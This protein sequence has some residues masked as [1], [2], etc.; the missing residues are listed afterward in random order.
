MSSSEIMEKLLDVQE[1]AE[2]SFGITNILQPG[3][4]KELI[5]AEILG[6][7]LVPQKDLPDA[8]DNE[9][10]FYEYLASIN[11]INTKTNRGCS[12]QMDRVTSNNLTRVTRNKA[13]YFGI[14]RTH[15]E[16]D[17]IWSVD[18]PNVLNEVQ[19]Q[20]ANCKNDIAHVNF[21]L[22]WLKSNGKLVYSNQKEIKYEK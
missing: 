2:K 5:M 21:L 7:K 22:K 20:L 3:I 13:F 16:I 12:F 1:L 8:K 11:R 6:H 17:Q 15:L 9:G 18:I 4:I 14:F 19:R 10:N